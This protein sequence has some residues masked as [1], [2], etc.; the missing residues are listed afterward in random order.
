[1]APGK[2]D[3]NTKRRIIGLLG[4]SF[5]PAHEG[6]LQLSLEALK[7]LKLDAVWWLISPQNPLKNADDM[8]PYDKRFSSAQ[9]IAQHPRIMVSDIEN[10]LGTRYSVDT[11]SRL[12]Q[13]FP[14]VQFVWLM[15]ADNLADLHL[16]KCWQYF[17]RIV[18]I[19]VFDRA[20]FSH[21]AQYSKAAGYMHKF[22][23]RN[24]QIQRGWKTPAL[25]F[26]PMRRNPVSST[27][28]RKHLEKCRK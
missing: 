26:V 25:L 2:H 14:N 10:Q 18:P 4:G 27:A 5:N 12:Q 24:S 19:A 13:R 9:K 23:L 17:C 28:L 21:R 3:R 15:G 6:H 20:P 8:A 7:R 22:R 11:V 1:M 16:W